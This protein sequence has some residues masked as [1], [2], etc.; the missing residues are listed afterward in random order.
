MARCDVVRTRDRCGKEA[1]RRRTEAEKTIS[2]LEPEG[3]LR[4]APP[5]GG[6]HVTT[7]PADTTNTTTPATA[8]P[9]VLVLFEQ[10]PLPNV[11][12]ITPPTKGGCTPSGIP[13]KIRRLHCVDHLHP[14][15]WAPE[16]D[17]HD[18]LTETEE[19][20]EEWNL[21]SKTQLR[22]RH[23]Q[24]ALLQ[25]ALRPARNDHSEPLSDARKRTMPKKKRKSQ[26]LWQS[27]PKRPE[28]S[29]PLGITYTEALRNLRNTGNNTHPHQM[30]PDEP[31]PG[32]GLERLMFV[33]RSGLWSLKT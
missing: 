30:D 15:H 18:G 28:L 1:T 19:D 9:P 7:T 12:Q 6:E 14:V 4:R 13:T 33:T 21:P 5:S 2:G 22:K 3:S 24:E 11:D 17:G 32:P 23:W 10:R 27:T 8:T 31:V 25:S 29:H 20:D 26:D 16:V